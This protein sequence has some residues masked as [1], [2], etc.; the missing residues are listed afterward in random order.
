MATN[1]ENSTDT[2][3]EKTGEPTPPPGTE[4]K[5]ITSQD[6]LNKIISE[7]IKRERGKF[8]DYEDLKAKA[9]RLSTL[10]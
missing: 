2:G 9:S 7:R 1:S 3:G 6:D 10:R 4:F 5:P 8:A